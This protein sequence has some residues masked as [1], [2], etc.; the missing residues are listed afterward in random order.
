[1]PHDCLKLRQG[2]IDDLSLI[3]RG[4][5][6]QRLDL[7]PEIITMQVEGHY[8][9]ILN[10]CEQYPVADLTVPT[11]PNG[12]SVKDALALVAA[13]TW[14]CAALLN[15]ARDSD[16]LLQGKPDVPGLTDEF[17]QERCNW[18]WSEVKTDFLLAQQALLEAIAYLPPTRL[19]DSLIQRTLSQEIWER[20]AQYIPYLESELH[21]QAGNL[22]L[23]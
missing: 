14:R 21:P 16:Q 15:Q 7:T 17:H 10:S 5:L 18:C 1:M 20:H 19:Q 22:F 9:K 13:W 4:W 6:M 12:W 2:L 23:N 3:K 8:L 11:L